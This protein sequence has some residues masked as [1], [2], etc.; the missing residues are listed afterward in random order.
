MVYMTS[1]FYFENYACVLQMEKK[2]SILKE[3]GKITCDI[4]CILPLNLF[5]NIFLKSYLNMHSMLLSI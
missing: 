4:F 5:K 3:G 2:S 1:Y